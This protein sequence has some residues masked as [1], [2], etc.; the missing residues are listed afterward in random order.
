M[1]IYM[2]M[3]MT[4]NHECTIVS[5]TMRILQVS[6]SKAEYVQPIT[7]SLPLA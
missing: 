1:Y 5:D 3:H 7:W 4:D 6:T 2:Y